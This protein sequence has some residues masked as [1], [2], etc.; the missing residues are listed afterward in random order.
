MSNLENK[1]S[2]SNHLLGKFVA[3]IISVGVF[4][5]TPVQAQETY[6]DDLVGLLNIMHSNNDGSGSSSAT[7]AVE[8]VVRSAGLNVDELLEASRADWALKRYI[9]EKEAAV[10]KAGSEYT[11]MEKAP[12]ASSEAA[13]LNLSKKKAE[14]QEL[15]KDLSDARRRGADASVK[16][17]ILRATFD[18]KLATGAGES[19]KQKL[20]KLVTIRYRGAGALAAGA[21]LVPFVTSARAKEDQL[22]EGA[23]QN[24]EP[25]VLNN[26]GDALS[27]PRN[28]R[29]KR[30]P[31]SD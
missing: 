14:V 8:D 5:M 25:S 23:L 19:I 9:S 30:V 20:A 27:L 15:A 29:S 28:A 1:F 12:D 10:N 4:T 6:F 24:P 16:F 3:L 18:A 21:V 26:H 7:E 11:K 22:P 2:K 17:S 31:S 13:Q